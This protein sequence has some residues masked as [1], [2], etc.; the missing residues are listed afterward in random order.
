MWDKEI[1]NDG[2][3]KVIE[4]PSSYILY[5]WGNYGW[6]MKNYNYRRRNILSL[7]RIFK[8]IGKL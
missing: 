6:E 8:H 3:Y 1:Y 7:V 2:Q 5:V 4:T